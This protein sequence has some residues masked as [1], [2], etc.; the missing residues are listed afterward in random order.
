MA[1]GDIVRTGVEIMASAVS[2]PNGYNSQELREVPNRIAGMDE[3]QTLR[4]LNTNAS[5][6]WVIDP[7]YSK[8]AA[9]SRFL[10]RGKRAVTFVEIE[11]RADA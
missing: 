1:N 4:R 7:R 9:A 2:D 6:T 5:V 8:P 3:E 11:R 10:L